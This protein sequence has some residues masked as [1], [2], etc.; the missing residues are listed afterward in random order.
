VKTEGDDIGHGVVYEKEVAPNDECE[1]FAEFQAPEVPGKYI[2][3]LR[4]IT[5]D[6]A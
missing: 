2:I 5:Q 6:D 1:I 4:L 3:Y